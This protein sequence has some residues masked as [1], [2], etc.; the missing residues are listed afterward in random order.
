MQF[1]SMYGVLLLNS[2][3]TQRYTD[4]SRHLEEIAIFKRTMMLQSRTQFSTQTP[5]T[6]LTFELLSYHAIENCLN[7]GITYH[8]ELHTGTETICIQRNHMPPV[9]NAYWYQPFILLNRTPHPTKIQPHYS[10]PKTP[11]TSFVVVTFVTPVKL[12]IA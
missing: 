3:C 7:Q 4:L 6:Y 2:M 10:N 9:P 1:R 5:F 12:F 11:N 8:P